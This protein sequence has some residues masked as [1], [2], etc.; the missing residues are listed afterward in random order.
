MM[1]Q[2]SEEHSMLTSHLCQWSSLL[3]HLEDC[4]YCDREQCWVTNVQCECLFSLLFS[5]I[6]PPLTHI[7][8][9]IQSLQKQ[10][11]SHVHHLSLWNGCNKSIWRSQGYYAAESHHSLWTQYQHSNQPL[12][13]VHSDF[14]YNIFE[15]FQIFAGLEG[16]SAYLSESDL[17]ISLCFWFW[18][19]I[20]IILSVFLHHWVLL[21]WKDLNL[22]CE[23]Y[24]QTKSSECLLSNNS[25]KQISILI[26]ILQLML[27]LTLTN[28][29]IQQVS[30]IILVTFCSFCFTSFMMSFSVSRYPQSE[31]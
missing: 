3:P 9:M 11:Q 1:Y 15:A 10:E 20:Y 8:N 21:S 19:S 24:S 31:W 6:L 28:T 16:I 4:Q 25:Q 13:S 27:I 5:F 18:S 26:S 17:Q 23:G 14:E 29:M 2:W 12:P 22:S 30:F 7:Q